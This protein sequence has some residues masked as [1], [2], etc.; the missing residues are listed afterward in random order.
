[1]IVFQDKDNNVFHVSNSI[2]IVGLIIENIDILRIIDNIRI[3]QSYGNPLNY[4]ER[5]KQL[6]DSFRLLS[7][8]FSYEI[9][10]NN[11]C[12]LMLPK[13]IIRA[14][15]KCICESS[16]HSTHSEFEDIIRIL[17]HELNLIQKQAVVWV[18]SL[19]N[20]D[21]GVQEYFFDEYRIENILKRIH[22]IT[23]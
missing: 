1:M 20:G 11:T 23:G 18:E 21:D 17:E 2:K 3:Q 10:P 15:Y 13:V 6:S 16:N 4:D 8:R 12:Y 5:M 14:I 7:I 19:M 9:I 22:E